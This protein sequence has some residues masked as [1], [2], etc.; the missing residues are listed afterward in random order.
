MEHPSPF[1]PLLL[2][3]VLAFLVPILASRSR[4]VRFPIVVGEIL[5]GMIIGQSGFDLVEPSPVLS[6]LAEFGFTFLMFLYCPGFR[7]YHPGYQFSHYSGCYRNLY[8]LTAAL[9]AS[10][11][12]GKGRATRRRYHSGN[13]P[14][15]GL[16]GAA[17]APVR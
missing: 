14:I 10:P 8:L 7:N 13:R 4:R 1:I 5:A 17:F 2:I 9:L 3:T 6:F 12:T 16:I 15:S 11:A